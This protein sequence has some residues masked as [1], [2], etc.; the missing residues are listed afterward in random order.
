[1]L[2]NKQPVLQAIINHISWKTFIGSIYTSYGIKEDPNETVKEGMASSTVKK[3]VRPATT[4][5]Q[6]W[7]QGRVNQPEMNCN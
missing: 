1:M 7:E 5:Q 4:T 2:C 3:T 6:W